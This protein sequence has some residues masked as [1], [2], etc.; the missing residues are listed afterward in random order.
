MRSDAAVRC[1]VG[2]GLCTAKGGPKE[3]VEGVICR[4][5]PWGALHAALDHSADGDPCRNGR[6]V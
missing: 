1:R 2:G 4:L 6:A 5:P 3:D